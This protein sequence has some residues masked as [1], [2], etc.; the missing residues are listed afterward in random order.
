MDTGVAR[1]TFLRQ[2]YR[3]K[4]FCQDFSVFIPEWTRQKV[5]KSAIIRANRILAMRNPR[6]Q[7]GSGVFL[8]Q[9]VCFTI[10][11]PLSTPVV[12]A[13]PNVKPPPNRDGKRVPAQQ[14]SALNSGGGK[15]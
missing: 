10:P 5:P 1:Y 3:Q 2:V 14:G 4:R 6:P 9:I 12:V 11:F 15:V 7:A 13:H 8:C